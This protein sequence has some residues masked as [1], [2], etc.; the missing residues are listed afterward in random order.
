[1]IFWPFTIQPDPAIQVAFQRLAQLVR[2]CDRSFTSKHVRSQG[3]AAET[4]G[5]GNSPAKNWDFMGLTHE[6]GDVM[7]V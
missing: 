5:S 6:N 7:G 2:L 1:M 3:R 4:W